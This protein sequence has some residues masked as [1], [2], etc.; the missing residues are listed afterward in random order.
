MPVRVTFL[1]EVL[2]PPPTG[3][4]RVTDGRGESTNWMGSALRTLWLT[5]AIALALGVVACGGGG[6]DQKAPADDL[7]IVTAVS[8]KIEKAA[9]REANSVKDRN[10]PGPKQVKIVCLTPDDA[11]KKGTPRDAVQCHVESFTTP[12]KKL[13]KVAYVWSEDWRVPVQDGKLGEPEIVGDYRI[14]NFLRKDDRL[15]CSGGKTAQE[16]CTGV[17]IPPADQSGIQGGGQPPPTNGQQEVP[18]NP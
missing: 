15:N 9:L 14:K 2:A 13:P 16:R 17:F 6:G 1:S 4:G 8:K 12:T 7:E 10:L 11:A 5:A 3:P 18:V